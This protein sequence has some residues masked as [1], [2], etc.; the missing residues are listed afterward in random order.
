MLKVVQIP[1]LNDNYIYLLRDSDSGLTAA[2]DPAVAEP[3]LDRIAE[4]G[5]RL[6]FIM[7][8]H[9]HGDHVGG[10]RELKSQTGCRVVGAKADSHRI[11][12]IDIELS[13]GDRFSLGDTVF[14]IIETPGHTLGHIVYYAAESHALFCGD[15]LF[16]MGCGRLFEGTAEQMWHSLERLRALPSA[17]R[18]YCAHEYTWNNG[19][20]ALTVEPGN[21]AL[22]QRME[23]VRSLR[24]EDRPTVPFTIEEEVA[25]NPFFRADVEALKT[26]VA[27][28]TRSPLA[29]F[30]ELRSRKDVF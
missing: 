9:H 7:N 19:R 15:T 5:W 27:M 14:E 12:G 25:T 8:T 4:L 16:A 6:D 24:E 17:T 18:V 28:E 1:A 23:R 2:V 20:F 13:E 11:P 26:A 22:L 30:T 29:V 10:N 3:V 21:A